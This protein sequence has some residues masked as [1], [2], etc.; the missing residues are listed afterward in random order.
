[1]NDPDLTEK[2]VEDLLMMINDMHS[3]SI[4]ALKE[5]MS[6]KSI[7]SS[8]AAAEVMADIMLSTTKTPEDTKA[9]D[10]F[11]RGDIYDILDVIRLYY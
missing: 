4:D 3:Q 9:L 11:T 2:E 7:G 8:E 6:F 1:M 10:L 5:S